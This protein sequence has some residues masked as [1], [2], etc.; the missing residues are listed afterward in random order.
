MDRMFLKL[1]PKI[2]VRVD[3]AIVK[4]KKI[5]EFVICKLLNHFTVIFL[6]IGFK[7]NCV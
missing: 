2:L 6:F 1:F 3:Q 7:A 5:N 4:G